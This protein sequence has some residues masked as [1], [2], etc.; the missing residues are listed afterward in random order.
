MSNY[1]VRNMIQD[2]SDLDQDRCFI[3]FESDDG[4]IRPCKCEGTNY[5]VHRKCLNQWI[6][7]SKKNYCQICNYQYK[8]EFVLNPSCNRFNNKNCVCDKP[9]SLQEDDQDYLSNDTNHIFFFS[10]FFYIPSYVIITTTLFLNFELLI[11]IYWSLFFLQPLFYL[12]LKFR[13]YFNIDILKIVRN[14]Q[15]LLCF[16]TFIV[17]NI[18]AGQFENR[19][20]LNCK[21]E[22]KLCDSNCSYFTDLSKSRN[23]QG[24]LVNNR[25]IT[26]GLTI[27]VDFILRLKDLFFY[28]RIAPYSPEKIFMSKIYPQRTN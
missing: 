2:S 6:R 15:L 9:V 21:Y 18:I 10:L 23:S 28:Q 12:L 5:S 20:S 13:L 11:S 7:T 25:L 8:Y 3:C 24:F 19:C 4:L 17:I 14:T 16:I 27:L 1:V 22:N 26:F